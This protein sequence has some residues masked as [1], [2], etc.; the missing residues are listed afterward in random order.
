MDYSKFGLMATTKKT[1]ASNSMTPNTLAVI[2]CYS[3]DKAARCPSIEGITDGASEKEVVHTLGKP[4]AFKFEGVTKSL[5]YSGLGVRL[6]L[7]KEKVY[8]LEVRKV[9]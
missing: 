3:G 4:S 9:P 7:E 6:I 1:L 8:L 2:Q 5:Q